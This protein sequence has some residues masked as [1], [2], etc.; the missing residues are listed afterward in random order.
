MP[1]KNIHILIVKMNIKKNFFKIFLFSL[2]IL[3]LLTAIGFKLYNDITKKQPINKTVNKKKR[4]KKKIST[5]M[6]GKR[7]YIRRLKYFGSLRAIHEIELFSKEESHIVA[8][9]ADISDYVQ[10]GQLL[11][12]LDTKELMEMKKKKEASKDVTQASL[13]KDRVEMRGKKLIYQRNRA[14]YYDQ[15]IAKQEYDSASI[16]YHTALAQVTL[17]EAKVK[18]AQ[19]AIS[20]LDTRINEMNIYSPIMGVVE[21]RYLNP[22]SLAKKSQP[23]LTIMSYSELKL[24]INIPERDFSQI[25][26]EKAKIKKDIKINVFV[27]ALG[28]QFSARIHK[29]Y[30]NVDIKTRTIQLEVRL[31][32]PKRLLKPGFYCQ[33][34]FNIIK[35]GQALFIPIKAVKRDVIQKKQWVQVLESKKIVIREVETSFYNN[36]ELIVTRGLKESVRIINPYNPRLKQGDIIKLAD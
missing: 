31:K 2:P 25:I 11:V 18:E 5:V 14:A 36:E 12:E 16:D 33:A 30:P 27:E 6:P 9:Y 29:I 28:Q 35:K 19:S 13:S 10:K 26:T 1:Y 34:D 7:Q 23:I 24:L 15:V 32:N 22:G 17:A 3:A 8:I 20:E 21:K 4:K